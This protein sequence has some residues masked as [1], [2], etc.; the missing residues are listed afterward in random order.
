MA[1]TLLPT[2]IALPEYSHSQ[3]QIGEHIALWP[4]GRPELAARARSVPARYGS[5][6]SATVL[7]RS[8]MFGQE[9][10]PHPGDHGPV[11][12]V[13]PGFRAETALLQW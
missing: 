2:A 4:A 12:A 9:T 8:R 10:R 13:G 6:S 5:L 1:A 11:P 7:F 3:E